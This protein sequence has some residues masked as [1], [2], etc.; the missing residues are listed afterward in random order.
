MIH[1][2]CIALYRVQVKILRRKLD[3]MERSYDVLLDEVKQMRVRVEGKDSHGAQAASE[4][5]D[6][7]HEDKIQASR[8]RAQLRR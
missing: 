6:K 8:H 4:G 7:S 2:S 1:L 5:A 3:D